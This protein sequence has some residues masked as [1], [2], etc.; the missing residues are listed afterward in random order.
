MT[1][2]S[3]NAEA[4]EV[5]NGLEPVRR[6]PGMYTDTTRPNHLAQEVIDN[7]CDYS[8]LAPIHGSTVQRYENEFDGHL[9]I[10]RQCGPHR[11]LVGEDGASPV[12]HTI[13]KY[14]GPGVLISHLTG[15]YESYLMITHTPVED[16]SIRVWHALLVKSPGD[17]AVATVNDEVAARQFQDASLF[18]FKQ[19]FQVWTNKAPCLN[20]L[21]LPSD[22]PFMK[23][24][25]WYKQ[26]FNPRDRKS[27]FQSKVQGVYVPKGTI[28]YT[29]D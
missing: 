16:G 27:E 18:A 10:Q 15:F 14:H 25:I 28:A 1:N 9:A 20:G 22:G 11:T 5:L 12:L 2:Q 17:N 13:T 29:Q 7:I 8:H 23:V 6:R 21:F 4:I 24:R 19:D 26:F 3:Y